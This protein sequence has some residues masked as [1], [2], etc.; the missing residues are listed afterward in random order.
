MVSRLTGAERQKRAREKKRSLGLVSMQVWVPP[1][2]RK[3][4]RDLEA[5]LCDTTSTFEVKGKEKMSEITTDSLMV[6]LAATEEVVNEEITIS[7]IEGDTPII[8]ATVQDIDEF[9]VML[10]VGEAQI[11]AMTDLWGIEDVQDDKVDE[12]NAVLLRAN[13][14]VPLSAFSIV[15]DRYVLFGA[16]SINSD[17]AEI[18]EEIV[19][20]SNNVVDAIE[21]CGEYLRS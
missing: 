15:G 9:P 11:L 5:R 10:S 21:F 3:A 6:Q 12:L 16:L 13:M 14:P 20:L 1:W 8:K 17:V 19:T 18:V 2:G 7:R 4:M